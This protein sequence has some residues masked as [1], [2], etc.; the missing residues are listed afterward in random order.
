MALLNIVSLDPI[1]GT[2]LYELVVKKPT[3]LES[4]NQLNLILD[5]EDVKALTKASYE[6]LLSTEVRRVFC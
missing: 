2:N 4:I 5:E 3:G 6:A 1:E